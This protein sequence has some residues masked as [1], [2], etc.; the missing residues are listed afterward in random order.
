[1]DDEMVIA[2]LIRIFYRLNIV[3]Y[4]D[5]DNIVDIL[6]LRLLSKL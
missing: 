2:E 4:K 5:L 1:M 3:K 6:Q